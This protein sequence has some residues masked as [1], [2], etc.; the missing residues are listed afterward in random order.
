M[1]IPVAHRKAPW[2]L[3]PDEWI[4]THELLR[5][6]MLQVRE[7]H[8]PDGWNVG[9]NVGSVGGQSVEHAHCHLI[10]RYKEEQYAG[11]G[12]RWPFKQPQNSQG[13]RGFRE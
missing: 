3:S 5:S 12:L 1:V 6:M 9:W 8:R 11:K 4:V 2:D 7:S 10:P 13:T